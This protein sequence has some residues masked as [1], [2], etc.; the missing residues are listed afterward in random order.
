MAGD[1]EEDVWAFLFLIF[2]LY[3]KNI[4]YVGFLLLSLVTLASE[5]RIITVNICEHL[6]HTRHS[7]I[8]YTVLCKFQST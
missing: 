6:V 4:S 1:P 7:T 8:M 3:F 2:F 5:I